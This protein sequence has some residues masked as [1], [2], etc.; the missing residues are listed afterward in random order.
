MHSRPSLMLNV[1]MERR[2]SKIGARLRSSKHAQTALAYP[3]SRW[4][5]FSVSTSSSVTSVPSSC[6][7][8]WSNVFSI[9]A[10][11]GSVLLE[12]HTFFIPELL[13]VCS[14]QEICI[15]INEQN[16]SWSHRSVASWP[17][18][19]NGSEKHRGTWHLEPCQASISKQ[20]TR[21]QY[22]DDIKYQTF[23]IEVQ[24]FSFDIGYNM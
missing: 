3:L 6:K 14:K 9:L 1:S 23:N 7:F 10:G 12:Q 5:K 17:S 16:N 21:Y 11:L 18:P 13:M 22:M 4:S 24:W 15:C 8:L 2:C 20:N 19:L